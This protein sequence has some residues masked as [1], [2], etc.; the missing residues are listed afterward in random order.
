M[1]PPHFGV[2]EDT[3]PLP[4]ARGGD[5]GRVRAGQPFADLVRAWPRR[6][7][8]QTREQG[9]RLL[10][11]PGRSSAD[12]FAASQANCYIEVP[13]GIGMREAGDRLPFEWL[14]DAS[15]ELC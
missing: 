15:V 10:P 3:R 8:G 6:S 13:P 5:S 7:P 11:L 9:W 1:Y 14:V 12:L 2:W 4:P